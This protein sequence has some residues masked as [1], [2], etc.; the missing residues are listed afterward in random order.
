[1]KN[2]LSLIFAILIAVVLMGC[3]G[4]SGSPA[5]EMK[6]SKDAS[7]A[8]GLSIGED[9]KRTIN[10]QNIPL[11]LNEFLKGIS[12]GVK[13]KKARFTLEEAMMIAEQANEDLRLA[14]SAAAEQDEI[15]FLAENASRPEITITD[16]GLQY[17]VITQTDGSKPTIEDTISMHGEIKL[18]DGSTFQSTAGG[19]P[20]TLSFNDMFPGWSEGL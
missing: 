17:L 20:I 19:D 15:K 12:D 6:L 4:N 7:Y 2:K 16:S 10:E 11:N 14:R 1:M 18:I 3:K 5:G 8:M 13:D 9:F